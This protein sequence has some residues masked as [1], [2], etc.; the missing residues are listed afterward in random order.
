MVCTSMVS[1]NGP[2]D[3]AVV[4]EQDG[5]IKLQVVARFFLFGLENDAELIECHLGGE[6]AFWPVSTK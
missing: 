6:L 2:A 5:E 3:L 1:K 4:G